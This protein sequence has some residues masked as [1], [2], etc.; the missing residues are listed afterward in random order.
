MEKL[1]Q[2]FMVSR[3]TIMMDDLKSVHFQSNY[4]TCV[5]EIERIIAKQINSEK[6]LEIMQKVLKSV[7]NTPQTLLKK[8]IFIHLS[9]RFSSKKN[10]VV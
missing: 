6:W 7:S 4:Y 3:S 8:A 9:L 10:A 5:L 1:F 2:N